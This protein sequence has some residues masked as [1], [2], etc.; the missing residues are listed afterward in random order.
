MAHL[1]LQGTDTDYPGLSLLG[2]S[3]LAI[4]MD[5][6]GSGF[7]EFNKLDFLVLSGTTSV[8][9]ASRG[10]APAPGGNTISQ[11][12]ETTNNLTTVTLNGP[13]AFF[14]G[15]DTGQSNSGDGIVTDIAATATSPTKIHSSLTLID[16]SATTDQVKIFAGATN[17]GGAGNF[18]N[19]ASLNPDITI[20]YTGLTIKG[21][22]SGDDVIEND[23]KN[24][25]VIASDQDTIILGGAGAKATLGTGR[26]S[27]GESTIGTNETPGSAL[28]DKITFG[29]GAIAELIV[30]IGAEAGSTAGTTSIG[31]TKVVGAAAGME[32][33]FTKTTNSGIITDETLA[34]A[35]S[36]SLTAAENAAVAALGSPG[37]AYFSFHGSEY[38]IAVKSTE[39]AV[40]ANDAI[41]KLVGVTDIHHAS[42]S[43]GLVTLHV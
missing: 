11:M 28:G 10:L 17:T 21:G 33:D 19:G 37:V 32:I 36:T 15:Q 27:V 8:T 26:V 9:I 42:S 29:N 22:S 35:S 3:T 2:E 6:T 39:M 16:A 34:V 25:I 7:L 20:T 30:G 13:E 24:G 1:I 18:A 14:L 43:F 38:F 23:A 41:V 40:S 12:A 31:L 4:T 5:E